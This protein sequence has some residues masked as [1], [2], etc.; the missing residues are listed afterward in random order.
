MDVCGFGC[1]GDDVAVHNG[2]Y[3]CTP[4]SRKL[5][6]IERQCLADTPPITRCPICEEWY[7]SGD[8]DC[9]NG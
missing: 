5:L 6:A 9:P 2:W 4:E 8:T 3:R 1:T 7:H